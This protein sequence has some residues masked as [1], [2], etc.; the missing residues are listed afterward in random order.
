MSAAHLGLIYYNYTKYLRLLAWPRSATEAA[1]CPDDVSFQPEH[2]VAPT[3]DGN[4]W[5]PIHFFINGVIYLAEPW[6]GNFFADFTCFR[7]GAISYN[8]LHGSRYQAVYRPTFRPS[9]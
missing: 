4:A 8:A 6:R 5:L 2:K 7:P 3:L 1:S 9:T